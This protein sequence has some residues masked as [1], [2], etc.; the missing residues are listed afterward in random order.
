ME[1][2]IITIPL[3][4]YRSEKNAEVKD[5]GAIISEYASMRPVLKT[6]TNEPSRKWAH[7]Q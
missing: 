2:R 4:A 7:T 3:D 6:L 5:T 1:T